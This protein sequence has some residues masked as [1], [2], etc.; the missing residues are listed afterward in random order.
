[1][2]RLLLFISVGIFFYA[3]WNTGEK[4]LENTSFD[5]AIEAIKS[6]IDI[7]SKDPEI[8]QLIERISLGLQLLVEQLQSTLEE[9]PETK[10]NDQASPT[11]PKPQLETPTEQYFSIHN[12]Q[13]GDTKEHVEKLL[14]A[15]KRSTYNEYGIEWFAYHENYQNFVMVGYEGN[16]LVAG[17]YTNQDLISSTKNITYG[18]TRQQV[19]DAFGEPLNSINKGRMIYQFEKDRDYEVYLLN[20]TYTTIFYDKH[21]DNIVT[22]IQ[23]VSKDLEKAKESFYT[24]GTDQLK[25]GFE[26]QLFDLTNAARV[27]HGLPVLEWD[28]AVRET[29]RKHSA[30]MAQNNYFSHTNLEGESPFD[31][32]LEDDIVFNVAGEN[33]AYGQFSSIFAHEGL[34]NSVGHRENILQKDYEYLGVGVA[35]NQESQPYYTE[36]Y[37]SK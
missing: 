33:L 13:V 1:M 19:L 34:M 3:L 8:T 32:M 24:E 27:V 30:D 29:A 9:L 10:T 2:R 26:Y 23:M 6:E 31:R 21:R 18:S 11:I 22:A 5:S 20:N 37:F 15:P 12:V 36:N 28:E 16:G 14:G 17:L 7:V 4:H 25:E 35:F